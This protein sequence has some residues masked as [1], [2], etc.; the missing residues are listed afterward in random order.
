MTMTFLSEVPARHRADAL[1]LVRRA[2]LRRLRFPV[3]ASRC[4]YGR[5]TTSAPMIGRDD[6]LGMLRRGFQVGRAGHP[7]VLVVRGE[8]GIGKSRLLQEFLDGIDADG[9]PPVAV[10]VGQCVDLGD[11]GAPFTPVRRLLRDLLRELGD[12]ALRD[13]ARTPGVAAAIGALLPEFTADAGA[14]P[15][16]HIAEAVERVLE[17]LSESR[18]LVLVIEDLHWA[19]AATLGL[20]PALSVTAHCRHL[21]FVLTYRTDDVGRTHPLR[22]L[23]AELERNRAVT[24]IDLARLDAAQSA[25]LIGA[26]APGADAAELDTL[27]ARGD[28]VPF[29]LEELLAVR[30]DRLPET[31]RDL[32]LSRFDQLDAETRQ[33]LSAAAI[34]GMQVDDTLLTEVLGTEASAVR[35]AMRRAVEAGVLALGR[36][37]VSF[38]H[39]LI[40]E[41]ATDDLLPGER[42]HLHRVYAQA[43]Q[44]EVDAGAEEQAAAAA[45]HWLAARDVPAA[46][47]ATATARDVAHRTHATAA[48]TRL[49]ERLVDLWPQV[50]DAEEICGITLAGLCHE[51][52]DEWRSLNDLARSERVA[53]TS[54]SRLTGAS[55]HE[56]VP[57]LRVLTLA[58]ADLGRRDEAVAAAR[59][60]VDMMAAL[61]GADSDPAHA[62]A[63]A[64]LAMQLD[65]LHEAV[66]L[67]ERAYAI[68]ERSGDLQALQR[69][70]QTIGWLTARTGDRQLALDVTLR[71]KARETTGYARVV[72]GV[73]ECDALTALGR[74][75]EAVAA[76]E[77]TYA[78]AVDIGLERGVGAAVLVNLAN[79]LVAL[80]DLE[81][82]VR[83]VSDAKGSLGRMALFRSAA[84]RT[85]STALL[86]SG[87]G[88]E[89]ARIR[90]DEDAFIRDV[91]YDA[92]ERLGW[93]VVDAEAALN[94]IEGAAV[95]SRVNATADEAMRVLSG[96]TEAD[97]EDPG[98]FVGAL[99]VAAR[100]AAALLRFGVRTDEA[101]ALR[102][103]VRAGLAALPASMLSAGIRAL[104]DA[105][106]RDGSA[107]WADAVRILEE[108]P[109]PMHLIDYARY[110]LVR[111]V[112]REE[113]A[114]AAAEMC[115]ALLPAVRTP[116]VSSWLRAFARH[117][118]TTGGSGLTEREEQ[119]LALVADG[120][121]N[122]Q[123]GERLFIS[124]KTASVHVSAILAK[125]GAANRTEA[126][127]IRRARP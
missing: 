62:I 124:P 45:E 43:L 95:G 83:V 67:S 120:L 18:H 40:R 75:R 65:D 84:L 107:E 25:A 3:P 42:S 79:A 113:S 41:L 91:L 73:N 14:V 103:T 101:E 96:L 56:Q 81:A 82:A 58:L 52:A 46:F 33:L 19:D 112:A 37:G 50:P 64:T 38:R 27:V 117:G 109:A 29:F 15:G 34:G 69:A 118:A 121:T 111:S 74:H 6:E 104:V 35:D 36:D 94:R 28:G 66:A 89:A 114:D 44:R 32:V 60:A 9:P 78:L 99:P 51:V 16:E 106:E 127:A 98:L 90:R 105:E 68:A 97:Q 72:I 39:A 86:W 88:D 53:R 119:V 126:A 92:E 7:G 21:T 5:M 110:R 63:L 61:P 10:A 100:A 13:A 24:M 31:L 87:Q 76:A 20:L 77:E 47:R 80:G 49:G 116:A 22:P 55:P 123:I 8:A 17:N 12:A 57:I 85:L 70:D 122:R 4:Q 59:S 23:L 71:M 48:A 54:L 11:I 30:G 93:I 102:R 115:R 1:F 26:L 125:I 2:H 108:E